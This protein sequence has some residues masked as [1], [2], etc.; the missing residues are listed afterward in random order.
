[1]MRQR[2]IRPYRYVASRLCVLLPLFGAVVATTAVA[3]NQPE[4]FLE[5]QAVFMGERWRVRHTLQYDD[6][7]I[8]PLRLEAR[9]RQRELQ[10][11]RE[12]VTAHVR[13]RHAAYRELEREVRTGFD[14]QRALTAHIAVLERELGHARQMRD[15]SATD[16]MRQRLES[17]L[18]DAHAQQKTD[19][20]ALAVATA[21]LHELRRE[22]IV[23]DAAGAQLWQIE[24][25]RAAAFEEAHR[26]LHDAL[27][28]HPEVR[29]LDAAHARSNRSGQG[30]MP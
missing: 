2:C 21:R 27:D 20:Q 6:D 28:A 18:G 29:R 17:E 10:D 8:V 12:E 1:M 9:Q 14:N 4:I 23:T 25:Q 15:E 11:I 13:A 30:E 16:V 7:A 22:L 3:E 5:E 24:E 26:A 19:A